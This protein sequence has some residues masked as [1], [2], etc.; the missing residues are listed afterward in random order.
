MLRSVASFVGRSHTFAQLV[1]ALDRL[2]RGDT[3]TL[4]V[5]TYHRIDERNGARYPSLISAT[6]GD[7]AE[8]VS[9]LAGRYRPVSMLDV[10]AVQAG[11][12]SLPRRAVLVTF[13]DAYEDFAEVA[14]PILRRRGVP[15]TMFVP[16]AYPGCPDRTFW[17]DRLYAAV[18]L[19]D[20]AT[21]ERVFR[22]LRLPDTGEPQAAFAQLRDHLKSLPHS[23]A[24]AVV[25]TVVDEL[26][27]RGAELPRVLD[28]TTL[29]ALAAD[30]VTLGPHSRTHSLLTRVS[31][32]ELAGEVRGSM[33]ELDKATGSRLPI[34]AYPSGAANP[35]V[36]RIVGKA[37]VRLA[38][39]TRRGLNDIRRAHWLLLR[40]INV[41]ALSTTAVVNAQ[42]LSWSRWLPREISHV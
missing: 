19:T 11:H 28:W 14:W 5:L 34:F 16:T 15:V 33:E 17:W 8:Q 1:R 20:A 31:D 12:G 35:H 21:R 7:F 42:L 30:G 25:D 27:P 38:F 26:G 6:P 18:S 13:D 36:A 39:T 9:F 29:R 41:G 22:G 40:R 32:A 10:L 2:D 24:M 37:G 23:E 4:P 3:R